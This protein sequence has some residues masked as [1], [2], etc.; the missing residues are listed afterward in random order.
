MHSI[1]RHILV[2]GRLFLV[3][4]FLANTGFSFILYRCTMSG[5]ADEMACCEDP[6]PTGAG[7]CLETDSPQST[8]ATLVAHNSSCMVMNVVGGL[9]TDPKFVDK[10]SLARQLTKID[11]APAT[12]SALSYGTHVDRPFCL[13]PA[14]DSNDSPPPVEKY[15][16]TGAFLI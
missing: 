14:V 10:V 6:H 8:D 3:L 5:A 2:F 15:V 1:N 4:F 7:D 12:V 13:L 11:C 9:Q 16:L